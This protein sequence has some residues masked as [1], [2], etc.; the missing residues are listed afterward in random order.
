[1]IKGTGVDIVHVKRIRKLMDEHGGR[2]LGKILSS[3]EIELVPEAGADL[4]VAGRFAAKEALVKSSGRQF[5]MNKISVLNESS[6][7]PYF[8]GDALSGISGEGTI[9]LS[10]SH[11]TDYAVAFVVIEKV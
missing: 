11:D 1:M 2:F 6:G 9:H 8:Q 4:Y 3:E 10:I 7:R 5:S